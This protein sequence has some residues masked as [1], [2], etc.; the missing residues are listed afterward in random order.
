[1]QLQV[2]SSLYSLRDWATPGPASDAGLVRGSDHLQ[3]VAMQ[4]RSGG[5]SQEEQRDLWQLRTRWLNVFHIALVDGLWRAKRYNQVT[6]VITADSADEL[7]DKL[8]A[9][10]GCGHE[11]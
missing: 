10:M 9:T 3:E 8:T 2:C 11:R 5:M 7:S 4:D 6:H 1:M